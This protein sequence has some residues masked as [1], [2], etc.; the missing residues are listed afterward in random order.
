QDRLRR[1]RQ[2][3]LPAASQQRVA[4]GLRPTART[5]DDYA[6]GA[7]L[8]RARRSALPSVLSRGA[9]SERDAR[10][11]VNSSVDNEHAEARVTDS[12]ERIEVMITVKAAPEIS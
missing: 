9:G 4:G 5:R 3:A 10:S 11:L 8:L 6:R 1:V 7:P 2:E 12:A